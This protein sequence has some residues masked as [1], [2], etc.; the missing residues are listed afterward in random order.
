MQSLRCSYK[1]LENLDWLCM[2]VICVINDTGV[3]ARV[4]VK[5]VMEFLWIMTAI[6]AYHWMGF[7]ERRKD[8]K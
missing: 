8:L 7:H 6:L 5:D 2:E 4:H 1:Q 3:L